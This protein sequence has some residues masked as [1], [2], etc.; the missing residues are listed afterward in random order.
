M[1]LTFNDPLV[2]AADSGDKDAVVALIKGG[3]NP[4][5]KGDF[6]VTP[7]MRAAFRGHTHIAQML[8]ESGA[9][10][11]ASDVGGDTPLHLAARNGHSA[12]VKLLLKYDAF[13]DSPDKEKWTPLMRAVMAKQ[14][15]VVQVLLE[16]GAD[17]RAVNDMDE[18]ALVHAA[19]I[20]KPEIMD[21]LTRSKDFKNLPEGQEDMAKEIVERK[22]FKD[23]ERV[24]AAAEGSPSIRMAENVEITGADE[25]FGLSVP[26]S[27]AEKE[28]PKKA[29]PAQKD[30]EMKL[31]D[32]QKEAAQG[33]SFWG[34]GTAPAE[35]SLND[36]KEPEKALELEDAKK[37]DEKDAL[38]VAEKT[39]STAEKFFSALLQKK[40]DTADIP[41]IQPVT[42]PV[43]ERKPDVAP[44]VKKETTD[45]AKA[46]SPK[47]NVA[48]SAP[49][50]PLPLGGGY[51]DLQL[52]SGKGYTAP[53]SGSYTMQLG[54]FSNPEQA[55]FIWDNL[56]RRNP[57]V[58]NDLDPDIM[59][60]DETNNGREF[61][62]L[63]AGRYAL[64]ESA[65]MACTALRN[66]NIECFIV[67]DA[68]V[69]TDYQFARTDKPEELQTERVLP[70]PVPQ[71]SPDVSP[72]PTV[73]V[74][75]IP[76]EK[77]PF[78]FAR[79]EQQLP[80]SVAEKDMV[81]PPDMEKAMPP[82]A[83]AAAPAM[84]ARPAPILAPASEKSVFAAA[85]QSPA[86]TTLPP[87]EATPVA[88]TP[89][90]DD[91]PWKSD[92]R[93]VQRQSWELPAQTIASNEV[94]ALP[95]AP[96]APV[97]L[98]SAPQ[99]APVSPTA[100]DAISLES[101]F[102][103]TQYSQN[104]GSMEQY[105][106]IIRQY[107]SAPAP[108]YSDVVPAYQQVAPAAPVAAPFAAEAA[109]APSGP[110]AS[111]IEVDDVPAGSEDYGDEAYTNR[112]VYI[113]PSRRNDIPLPERIPVPTPVTQN[114]PVPTPY[115]ASPRAAGGYNSYNNYN[116]AVAPVPQPR[117]QPVYPSLQ[118]SAP[119]S[120]SPR[121]TVSEPVLVPDDKFFAGYSGQ[122]M[123]RDSGYWMDIGLFANR[124]LATDYGIRMFKYDENLS[125]LQVNLINK[126]SPYGEQVSLHVGPINNSA[127]ANSLCDTVR[128]GGMQ[129]SVMGSGGNAPERSVTSGGFGSPSAPGT[130]AAVP[131]KEKTGGVSYWV[132]LG[133]FADS[134]EAEYYW[135]FLQEDND[136]LLNALKYEMSTA[137][138][139]EFGSHA[140]QLRVGPF[141]VK[142]RAD[143]L[144]NS[145]RYRN[146]ACLVVQ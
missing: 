142:P 39:P 106:N 22:G 51:G 75:D 73:P 19:I 144:C 111:N 68:P 18:T 115:A 87:A 112:P 48:A 54:A 85:S 146:V 97:D 90:E 135:M 104:I 34:L 79:Q 25:E 69:R 60:A 76:D 95:L 134:P 38:P 26:A 61:Y 120:M 37:T 41:S 30:V 84:T 21:L 108:A 107:Q 47:K 101:E 7:L 46:A 92:P 86:Q 72:E 4:D 94:P 5:S 78:I 138:H 14:T 3:K 27:M 114:Q 77:D 118:D 91:L 67:Q 16:E 141:D 98:A 133:T 74:A 88:K 103:P 11:N 12:M 89:A 124:T 23:S 32:L 40:Q 130:K 59:T 131:V 126:P 100:S 15:D 1:A 28:E 123:R 136:D 13:I 99:V 49:K 121:A 20:G 62:R 52:S 43:P 140:V 143:Q 102:Q 93:Y 50:G 80:T 139:G 132:N 125:Y 44:V 70:K 128:A 122:S 9:Y 17:V 33:D 127:E 145:L 2:D 119:A 96:S 8:L 109:P 110:P 29:S 116:T 53:V 64:K 6:G 55:F 63:R 31:A 10:V 117:Q 65:E 137:K 71:L 113:P 83:V 66:R 105:N 129:C 82:L 56:K 81:S 58:L 24:L 42:T 57:D 35:L 36:T 45:V